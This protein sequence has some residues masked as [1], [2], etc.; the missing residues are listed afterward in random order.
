MSC[1]IP[2]VFDRV[3]RIKKTKKSDALWKKIFYDRELFLLLD[4]T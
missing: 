1:Y 4:L 2:L 3:L